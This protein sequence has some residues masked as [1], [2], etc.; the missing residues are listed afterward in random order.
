MLLLYDQI[1]I[2]FHLFLF[3][4]DLFDPDVDH[5]G[6]YLLNHYLHLD[7]CSSR[8]TFTGKDEL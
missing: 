7:G 1:P 5:I 8:A 4:S 6:N 3:G 2:G